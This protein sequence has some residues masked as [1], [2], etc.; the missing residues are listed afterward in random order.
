MAVALAIAA[1]ILLLGTAVGYSSSSS[2]TALPGGDVRLITA[3][4]R[5]ARRPHINDP[6]ITLPSQGAA[7]RGQA[8]QFH[9]VRHADALPA[10]L[11]VWLP[12]VE[13][14]ARLYLNNVAV[15]D[16]E[17]LPLRGF[18]LG[19]HALLAEPADELL[20]PGINRID[21]RQ[22]AS[23]TRRRLNGLHLGASSSLE[24]AHAKRAALRA[25]LSRLSWLVAGLGLLAA[26]FLFAGRKRRLALAAG[27]LALGGVLAGTEAGARLGIGAAQ[28]DA[29][30]PALLYVGGTLAAIIC[31]RRPAF[32]ECAVFGVA[33][34][35]AL[36]GAVGTALALSPGLVAQVEP[37][38]VSSAT[39]S[40]SG[41]SLTA[42]ILL[43]QAVGDHR[44][45]LREAQ[46]RI[47][48]QAATIA[49]QEADLEDAIR[50]AAV[51]EERQRFTRD[52]HDGIGGQLTSLLIRLRSGRA[53]MDTVEHD[54]RSGL[55][56]VRN[57]VDALDHVGD[58]LEG[59]F[60][61]FRARAEQQV[62]AAGLDFEWA[63]EGELSD[64]RLDTREVLH[65]YRLLQ[66]ALSNAL[67]HAA[68][69]RIRIRVARTKEALRMSVIDDGKGFDADA[70]R[71]GRG[72]RSLRE[73]AAKLGAELTLMSEVG[74]GTEVRLTRPLESV[75]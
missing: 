25:N 54:I 52:M 61:T 46:E 49:A 75:A 38:T 5:D 57:I 6:L 72:L 9:A 39:A 4:F 22:E 45:A 55:A 50:R 27:A 67:R 44:R 7:F 1:L 29:L 16:T 34:A 43:V 56:D 71:A 13:G 24:G 19:T 68:A 14:E 36:A 8:R 37:L 62:A 17:A 73:R 26:M 70:I 53:D 12:G 30:V 60:I 66:E 48:D 40:L 31:A 11:A 64:L 2:A 63:Q 20:L 59:A 74:K 33:L 41:A 10:R 58:D 35:T 15:K 18:G 47:Q 69:S 42:S 21:V 3:G 65:C 32:P 51:V 23:K 28:L